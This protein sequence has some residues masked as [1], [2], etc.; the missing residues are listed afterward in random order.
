MG[1]D[2]RPEPVAQC[3]RKI[4]AQLLGELGRIRQIGGQQLAVE[5]HLGIGEQHRQ[6]GPGQPLALRRPR[7]EG[8]VVG[9]EFERA[10]EPAR[11]FEIADQPRLAVESGGAA[12]LGDRQCLALQI[13]VAQHQGRDIL[14]HAVQQRLAFLGRERPGGDRPV[15]QDLEVDLVV[16][17]VDPGRIVDRVGV[18]AAALQRIGDPPALGHPEIGALADHLGADLVGVDPQRVIGP[19]ADFGM[20]FLRRLDKGADAAE[21]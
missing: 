12:R 5:R 21:P 15:D 8:L 18:D 10:V 20:A 7:R 6:F 9:Q 16:G 14:G 19:V 4:A 17:G 1:R 3:R 13:V 11:A 2:R